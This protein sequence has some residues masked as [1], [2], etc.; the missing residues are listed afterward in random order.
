MAGFLFLGTTYGIFMN[1]S[2]F[3]F[4]YPF[5]ISIV[6]FEGSMQ[7]V[8]VNMLLGAFN[9]IEALTVTLMI[10]ARH[11]FYGISL[12]DKYKGAGLKKIYL[13]F[14]VC[15]E[16]FSINCSADAPE[17][18]DRTQFMFFVTLLNQI[19][20]VVGSALGGLFGSLISIEIK[21]IDFV[22]TAMF[23]VILLEQILSGR[24]N[25]P[26][27]LIGLS[28]S[29]LSLILFGT[30]SFIIPAMLGIIV[31]LTIARRPIERI[32]LDSE[33]S[34]FEGGDAK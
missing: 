12:L 11:I 20:W 18:V 10:N 29:L 5:I 13:I 19:Y 25:L 17:G 26:S 9:P 1:L 27:V 30:D 32:S 16:T 14:G 24:K 22:M 31:S 15:D 3:S 7:F 6:V 4:W 21:G 8:A 34:V 28:M 23:V 33:Q 2:G